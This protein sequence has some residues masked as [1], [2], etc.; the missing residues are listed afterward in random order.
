[1]LEKKQ[2][3]LCVHESMMMDN[4]FSMTKKNVLI[5]LSSLDIELSEGTK[6]DK[7][8]PYNISNPNQDFFKN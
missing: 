6:K 5:L 7:D 2:A 1:M 8:N 3:I 4:S